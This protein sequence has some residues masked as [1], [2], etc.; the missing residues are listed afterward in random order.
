MSSELAVKIT[1]NLKVHNHIC[2]LCPMQQLCELCEYLNTFI[3]QPEKIYKILVKILETNLE[4]LDQN[5]LFDCLSE[6][7]LCLNPPLLSNFEPNVFM[8][9]TNQL[10][11]S[12]IHKLCKMK[13]NQHMIL[14]IR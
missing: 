3:S 4:L 11:V 12:L 5:Y 10:I 6:R 9:Q 2:T 14:N 7:N 13:Q 8:V 1:D